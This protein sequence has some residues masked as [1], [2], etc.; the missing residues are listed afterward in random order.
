MKKRLKLSRET[1][2][3]LSSGELIRANGGDD[4]WLDWTCDH[5][6]CGY[7]DMCPTAGTNTGTI[8]CPASWPISICHTNT[9]G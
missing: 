7:T 2:Q 8:N 3:N 1:L 6:G 5:G 4:S 9:C